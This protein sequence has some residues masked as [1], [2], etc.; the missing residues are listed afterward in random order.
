MTV[1]T[2]LLFT[3][4]AASSWLT[5]TPALAA[6]IA[7]LL[8]AVG[9]VAGQIASRRRLS[10]EI[11]KYRAEGHKTDADAAKV[12]SET[13]LELLDPYR[14]QI[15]FMRAEQEAERVRMGSQIRQLQRDLEAAITEAAAVRGQL[16]KALREIEQLRAQVNG[17]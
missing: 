4:A 14:K 12:I 5:S 16:T 8:T 11:K 13:A 3:V 15:E 10:A 6:A 7:G 1:S 17:S 9:T 2:D